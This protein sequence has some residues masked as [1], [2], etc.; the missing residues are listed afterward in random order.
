M[1]CS[2]CSLAPCLRLLPNRSVR[3]TLQAPQHEHT[4]RDTTPRRAHTYTERARDHRRRLLLHCGHS[5]RTCHAK[6]EQAHGTAPRPRTA[7]TASAAA[8]AQCEQQDCFLLLTQSWSCAFRVS[9]CHWVMP[10]PTSL[11]QYHCPTSTVARQPP[12]APTPTRDAH[13]P[14]RR[15]QRASV[16]SLAGAGS[17]RLRRRTSA[18]D[19]HG[20]CFVR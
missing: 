12:S 6:H 19:L 3:R 15:S 1:H 16:A 5:T 11:P 13:W 2:Q 8:P 7:G 9:G 4:S 10:Q 20:G 14:Y 18:T 17:S